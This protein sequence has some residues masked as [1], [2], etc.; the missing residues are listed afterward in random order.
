MNA[1]GQTM[2]VVCLCIN[3]NIKRLLKLSYLLL[4]TMSTI[5]DI[6]YDH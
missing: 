5:L 6:Y 3:P 2:N 4:T 1:P